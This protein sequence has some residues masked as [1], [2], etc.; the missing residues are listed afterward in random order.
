MHV[1]MVCI[2][3]WMYVSPASFIS[4]LVCVRVCLLVCLSVVVRVCRSLQ[5]VCVPLVSGISLVCL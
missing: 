2:Y 4:L 1:C 3:I 5:Y